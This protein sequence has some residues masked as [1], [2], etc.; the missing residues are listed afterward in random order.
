MSD[1]VV[2]VIRP[3]PFKPEGADRFTSDGK[4]GH[5][6]EGSV[7]RM[8]NLLHHLFNVVPCHLSLALARYMDC[9]F[10]R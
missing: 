10:V 6:A 4:T 7:G 9:C 5:D 1:D 8:R 2:R 3:G